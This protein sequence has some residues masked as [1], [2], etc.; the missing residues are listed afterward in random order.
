MRAGVDIKGG[1]REEE[2][3][4]ILAFAWRIA[5]PRTRDNMALSAFRHGMNV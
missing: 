2:G 3:R 1:W 5:A 4:A